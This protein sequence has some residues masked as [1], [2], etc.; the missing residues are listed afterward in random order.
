MMKV[1]ESS[2]IVVIICVRIVLRP[3]FLKTKAKSVRKVTKMKE[4]IL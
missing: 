2:F 1:R 3:V 4:W